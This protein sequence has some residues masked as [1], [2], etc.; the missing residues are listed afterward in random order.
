[1]EHI[2]KTLGEKRANVDFNTTNDELVHRI[3]VKSAELI[4]LC[5]TMKTGP[6]GLAKSGEACRAISLAQTKYEEAAMWAVKANFTK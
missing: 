1:M 3:K 4:D 6:D 5:N 2:E